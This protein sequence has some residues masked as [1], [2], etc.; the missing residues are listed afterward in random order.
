MTRVEGAERQVTV[1]EHPVG[2]VLHCGCARHL[3][4][5]RGK[6]PFLRGRLQG[7]SPLLGPPGLFGSLRVYHRAGCPEIP[8]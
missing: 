1:V 2:A 3:V 6:G 7:G 4:A 8:R 5:A